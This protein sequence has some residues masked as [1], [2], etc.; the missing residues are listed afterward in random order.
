MQDEKRLYDIHAAAHY[1]GTTIW[2]VRRLIW[3]QKIKSVR[4]GKRYLID[5]SDLDAFVDSLKAA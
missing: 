3:D 1:L 5:K 4:L 2:C